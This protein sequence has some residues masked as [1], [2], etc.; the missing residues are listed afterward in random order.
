MSIATL[1]A[2]RRAEAQRTRAENRALTN[3]TIG[4]SPWVRAGTLIALVVLA[5]LWLL[6]VVWGAVTSFKHE[7]EAALPASWWPSMGWTLDAYRSVLANSDLLKWMGNSL[8]VATL[9][10][11]LTV[12]ISAMAAFAFSQTLFKGRGLLQALTI[13]SIMLPGQ[14]L[15]VPL[16]RQMQAMGLVDSYAGIILP[17]IVAPVMVFILKR[18]FD[19]IPGEL[20][21]AARID[22]AGS[23]RLFWTIVVP[24]SRSILVA[25]AIFVFIGAWNNFLW[26]FIVTTDPT[27]MTLPV[28]LSTVKNAYGVQYAQNMASA[29]IAALPLLVVFMLFQRRIVQGV[30]TTGMGGQ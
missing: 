21:D 12:M 30:A 19:A 20:L 27:F 10:T 22:G 28:G 23:W 11:I 13:A 9:V 16:F 17:Q 7:A 18:F 25:V 6:P 3:L 26:P 2:D 24:L 15:I 5:A 8:I 29:I 4:P 14:I 1:V